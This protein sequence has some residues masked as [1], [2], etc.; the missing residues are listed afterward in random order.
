M[1]V[2]SGFWAIPIAIA[3]DGA[4]G[5]EPRKANAG[6]LR[7]N[8]VI[9]S[10][11]AA[12]RHCLAERIQVQKAATEHDCGAVYGFR[13]PGSVTLSVRCRAANGRAS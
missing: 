5:I 7:L 12:Q 4:P 13:L 11:S 2:V 6:S 10:A 1:F 9:S 3:I 8:N